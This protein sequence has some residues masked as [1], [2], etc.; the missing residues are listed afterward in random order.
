MNKEERESRNIVFFFTFV[1]VLAGTA[2]SLANIALIGSS[3]PIERNFVDENYIYEHKHLL[4]DWNKKPYV[5]IQAVGG[6]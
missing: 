1:L 5:D 6:N 2:L 4:E 3:S